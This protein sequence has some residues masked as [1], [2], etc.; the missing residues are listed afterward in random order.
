MVVEARRLTYP[1]SPQLKHGLGF[2][3]LGQS[4]LE[5]LDRVSKEIKDHA[6]EINLPFFTTVE[7]ASALMATALTTTEAIAAIAIVS[8]TIAIGSRFTS[9]IFIAIRSRLAT[10]PWSTSGRCCTAS[11]VPAAADS[12]V[13]RHIARFDDYKGDLGNLRSAENQS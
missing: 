6:L 7:A 4:F 13:P 1:S 9:A 12:S 11:L 5:W 8:S 3:G 2:A 10:V